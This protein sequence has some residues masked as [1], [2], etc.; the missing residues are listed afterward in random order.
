[1]R[2]LPVIAA[3]LLAAGPARA[4]DWPQWLGPNRDGSSPEIVPAWNDAPKVVWRAPVGQGH[5]SPIVSG[6]KVY[7]HYLDAAGLPSEAVIVYDA[8][9]GNRVT[10]HVMA[11]REPFN[12]PFGN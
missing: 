12:S 3:L 8:A 4:G 9:T 1:M 10:R 5:S 11:Q 6:G 7:L 2:L